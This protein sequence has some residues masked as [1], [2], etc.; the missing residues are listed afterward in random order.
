VKLV[1]E[2]VAVVVKDEMEMVAEETMETLKGSI[3]ITKEV[4]NMLTRRPRMVTK[5]PSNA[6][7]PIIKAIP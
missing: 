4:A 7:F 1:E 6:N 5:K 2:E 3:A